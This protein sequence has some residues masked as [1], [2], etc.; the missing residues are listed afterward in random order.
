MLP[1][2]QSGMETDIHTGKNPVAYGRGYIAMIPLGYGAVHTAI[3]QVLYGGAYIV[4][5]RVLW[6]RP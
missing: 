4:I 3:K 5:I 2:Y 6:W 1:L